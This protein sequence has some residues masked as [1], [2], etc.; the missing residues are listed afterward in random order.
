[1][2]EINH[3]VL[4]NKN[5]DIPDFTVALWNDCV[6]VM[7]QNA[8]QTLWNKLMLQAHCHWMGYTHY[9]VDVSDSIEHSQLTNSQKVAIAHL[10]LEQTNHLP[11]KV[12]LAI[13]MKM[14]VLSNIA[15]AAGLGNGSCSIVTDIVLDPREPLELLPASV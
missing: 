10:K 5:C 12:E 8:V 4:D 14:M 15:V 6:L 2:A 11:N 3:L 1:L 7:S 9:I 13:G